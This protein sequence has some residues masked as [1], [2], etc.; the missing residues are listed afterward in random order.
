M[1][2][3][4]VGN[5]GYLLDSHILIWLDTGN[6]L[7]TPA[8]LE[9]LRLAEHRYLSA[10][11]AW[12]LGLKQALHKIE[13][14]SSIHSMLPVFGLNELSVTVKHADRAATLPMFHKDPFDRM[15]V[16]QALE[17]NLILV[18]ADRRLLDYGVPLLVV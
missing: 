4:K 15:L 13:L 8:I 1:S 5:G 14:G 2:A 9:L 6:S 16:A 10:A 3:I 7:L 17:E 11:S 18:T 12:E